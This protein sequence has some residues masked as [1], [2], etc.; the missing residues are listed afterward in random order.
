MK[1]LKALVRPNV[2]MLAHRLQEETQPEVTNASPTVRLNATE[3]PF[4]APFNRFPSAADEETLRRAV[5]ADLRVRPE[6]VT[7]TAGTQTPVDAILRTFCSPQRDNIIVVEPSDENYVRLATLNDVEYRRVRLNNHFDISASTIINAA[8]QRTK[9]V[10][11]TSPNYPTG[12]LFSH[13][14]LL[15]LTRRFDGVVIVD[16]RYAAFSRTD[17]LVKDI[18][19]CPNLIIVGNLSSGFAAA[20][21]EV[22]YVVARPD[23]ISFVRA[24][25]PSHAIPT[26]I[27][28]RATELLTRRRYDVDKWVKWVLDEREKVCV[29]LRMLPF[30]RRVWPSSANFLLVEMDDAKTIFDQLA[31]ENILVENC[32]KLPGCNNCLCITIGL[33]VENSALL[34]CLRKRL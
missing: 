14:E 4:N 16:E 26:S 5:A 33:N 20:A 8:N 31:A 23:I 34:S 32:S 30:V 2:Q 18:S 15:L 1:E 7:V 19:T 13:N 24:V 9:A 27:A 21:L 28:R 11:L 3:S 29:S 12:N 25:L 22:G 6:A 17:S 10:F